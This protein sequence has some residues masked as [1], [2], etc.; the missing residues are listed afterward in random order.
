MIK[1]LKKFKKYNRDKVS[2]KDFYEIEA[3]L[4]GFIKNFS[5]YFG[6][7]KL[8]K[9]LSLVK[10]KK[11]SLILDLGCGTG[12]LTRMLRE[13]N[14]KVIGIDI[15]EKRIKEAGK[16]FLVGDAS[17]PPFKDKVFDC[18]IASDVIEHLPDDLNNI[19][20]RLKKLVKKKGK[21]II[22]VPYGIGN[23]DKGHIHRLSIPEWESLFKNNNLEIKAKKAANYS[24]FNIKLPI[25][26]NHVYLLK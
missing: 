18:V 21:M 1:L 25:K 6:R 24:L 20:K 14:Y 19:I 23:N 11:D 5:L 17:K 10:L 16:D 13:K 8:K 7:D 22:S 26:M 15:S 4:P 2:L 12:Y 3:T 9:I